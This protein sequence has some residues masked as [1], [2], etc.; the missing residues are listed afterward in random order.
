EIVHKEDAAH[1][2]G[3]PALINLFFTE[4]AVVPLRGK[5]SVIGALLVD[6]I[7]TKK[8]LVEGDIRRIMMLANHAGVALEN[9][10]TYSEVVITSQQ[11]SLTKL[12]N[13]GH[14]QNILTDSVREAK[15]KNLSL[16][17]IV[18]DVDDF[19]KYN[20]SFGHPAGDRALEAVSKIS[21]TV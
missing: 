14:F 11:D 4:F 13:H 10:K 18:F 6:N 2:L 5:D 15:T 9:A 20:D 16:S 7:T 12:W 17:L 21:K 1:E 8:P 3:N 19:K